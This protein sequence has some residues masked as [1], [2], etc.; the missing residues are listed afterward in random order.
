[1]PASFF[2]ALTTDYTSH[3][4]SP[5]RACSNCIRRDWSADEAGQNLRQN[6]GKL[7]WPSSWKKPTG[8]CTLTAMTPELEKEIIVGVVA[9]VCTALFTGIPAFLLFWWTW[10]RDQERL[11]V[12]KLL[13]YAETPDGRRVQLRTGPAPNCGVLIRNRSLFSVRISAVGFQIDDEVVELEHPLFPARMRRNPNP[14]DR[15]RHPWIADEDHDPRELDGGALLRVETFHPSDQA[16]LETALEAAARRH[17]TK[18]ADILAT[19]NVAALV[20]LE[21]GR[22]F[23][24]S[25]SRGRVFLRLLGIKRKPKTGHL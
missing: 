11:V 3:H 7:Y 18:A 17:R 2:D 8:R 14:V 24:S 23:T 10:Q 20:A 21:S 25:I 6:W 22:I 13:T 4:D 12:Q 9:A 15:E 19:R 16:R 1:M 5:R